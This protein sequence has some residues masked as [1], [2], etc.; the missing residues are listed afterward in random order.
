MIDPQ[1]ILQ[2]F[3][4]RP[5]VVVLERKDASATT[6]DAVHN[7]FFSKCYI[8]QNNY[9][10]EVHNGM[11]NAAKTVSYLTAPLESSIAFVGNTLIFTSEIQ[12]TQRIMKVVLTQA[13][14][15][16]ED[17]SAFA[18]IVET[19]DKSNKITQVTLTLPSSG[20]SNEIIEKSV[21]LLTQVFSSW[22]QFSLRDLRIDGASP[23]MHDFI[24]IQEIQLPGNFFLEIVSKDEVGI[25][26]HTELSQEIVID[27]KKQSITLTFED[28]TVILERIV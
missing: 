6:V 17:F 24:E 21:A 13:V 20:T 19:K 23:V 25:I 4:N 10:L 22:Q 9:V 3:T 7:V 14:A 12:Q 11:E 15:K 2:P 26:E 16:Q 28:G 8:K 27:F 5:I 18:E 1:V